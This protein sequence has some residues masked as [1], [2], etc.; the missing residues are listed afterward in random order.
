MKRTTSCRFFSFARNG[1]DFRHAFKAGRR[2][3]VPNG[4]RAVISSRYVMASGKAQGLSGKTE[5]KVKMN[6]IKKTTMAALAVAVLATSGVL[7]APTASSAMSGVRVAPVESS[8]VQATKVGW[9]HHRRHRRHWGHRRHRWGY[10]GCFW[11][12]RRFWNEYYGEFVYR[13]VRICF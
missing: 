2:V 13:R 11:K 6:S 5:R 8:A 4:T 9:R 7:A 10:G 12:K 3:S 1:R